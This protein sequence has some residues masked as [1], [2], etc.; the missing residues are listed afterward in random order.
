[1]FKKRWCTLISQKNNSPFINSVKICETKNRKDK[2]AIQH[3]INKAKRKL[4]KSLVVL[5]QGFHTEI[6]A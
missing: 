5:G 4:K 3:I 1:L 6:T 2:S